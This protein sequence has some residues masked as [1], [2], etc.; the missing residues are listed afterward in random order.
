MRLLARLTAVAALAAA[1]FAHAAGLGFSEMTLVRGEGSADLGLRAELSLN[2]SLKDALDGG[3][4]VTFVIESRVMREQIFVD[5]PLHTYRWEASMRRRDFGQGY[6]Y[7]RFGMDAWEQSEDVDGALEDM[8]ELRV[9]IDDP[10]VLLEL[11]DFEVYVSNRIE[12]DLEALPTPLKVDLMTT[13]GWNFSSGW[14][15]IQN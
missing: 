4:V 14:L 2:Q 13:S 11:K 6:E 5:K 8:G 15:R 7:R 9:T 1:A 12:V 3:Q 10:A